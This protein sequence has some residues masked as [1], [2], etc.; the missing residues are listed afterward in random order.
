MSQR[1][2]I[3]PPPP[4]SEDDLQFPP[5]ETIPNPLLALVH[6]RLSRRGQPGDLRDAI[7]AEAA[8]VSAALRLALALILHSHGLVSAAKALSPQQA[9]SDTLNT[10]Q[11]AIRVVLSATNF[12]VVITREMYGLPNGTYVTPALR[13][14]YDSQEARA[15]YCH[16]WYV[17]RLVAAASDSSNRSQYNCHL[18]LLATGLA[19]ELMGLLRYE[20]LYHRLRGI[21]CL[22]TP[23]DV[24][25]DGG[26]A[27]ERMLFDGHLRGMWIA[28]AASPPH[29]QGP[30]LAD[31]AELVAQ[32]EREF[33]TVVEADVQ[34]VSDPEPP[35]DR[36]GLPFDKLVITRLRVHC[37]VDNEWLQ[38]AITTLPVP[39]IQRSSA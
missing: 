15:V 11:T 16:S 34:P 2:P 14:M 28:I 1:R 32:I 5:P 26:R 30:L 21:V 22:T 39:E 8:C 10:V 20:K 7:P 35:S 17:D 18:L 19:H 6:A 25:G 3:T 31:M 38:G 29:V 27:W 12:L 33:G 9:T 4:F 24:D 23:H 37:E 36:R 13:V